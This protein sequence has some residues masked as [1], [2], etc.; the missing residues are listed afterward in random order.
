MIPLPTV[1]ELP[2]LWEVALLEG[3]AETPK[4]TGQRQALPQSSRGGQAPGCGCRNSFP[5]PDPGFTL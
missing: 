3:R 5:A 4:P 1:P 2:V